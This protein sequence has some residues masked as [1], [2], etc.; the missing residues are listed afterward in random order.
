MPENGKLASTRNALI[1]GREDGNPRNN[2]GVSFPVE[3]G[4]RR[5]RT[6]ARSELMSAGLALTKTPT[7]STSLGSLERICAASAVDDAA[8]NF[9][10]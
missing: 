2:I 1:T 8:E 4:P 5:N 3:L 10:R 7:A 9:F 6:K